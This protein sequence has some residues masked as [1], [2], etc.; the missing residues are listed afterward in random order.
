MAG[1]DA[2]LPAAPRPAP[3]TTAQA[4]PTPALLAGVAKLQ[5]LLAD[6][7]ADAAETARELHSLS[8]GTPQAAL[9]DNIAKAVEDFDFDLALALLR[10]SDLT[11]GA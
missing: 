2:G 10:E 7:D 11:E 3:A 1:L 5:R 4:A 6:Y 9:L 8:G